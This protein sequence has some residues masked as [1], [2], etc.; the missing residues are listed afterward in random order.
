MG[1]AVGLEHEQTRCDRDNF[2]RINYGNI[3]SGRAFNFDKYC[4]SQHRDLGVYDYNSLMHYGAY[5]FSA[6]T[7]PTISGLNPPNGAHTGSPLNFG[8]FSNL[9]AGD[10]ASINSLYQ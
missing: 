6:N 2:V 1:H 3:I 9:S 10:I 8:S 4:D 7:L 5:D